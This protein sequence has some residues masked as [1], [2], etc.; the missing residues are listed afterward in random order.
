MDGV[1]RDLRHGSVARRWK[2]T[3]LPGSGRGCYV[4]GCDGES[5]FPGQRPET[6]V[7]TSPC[8]YGTLHHSG[9]PDRSHER[10]AAILGDFARKTKRQTRTH[11]SAELAERTEEVVAS[12]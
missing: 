12:R 4:R 2:G 5:R 8:V 11:C 6:T 9:G 10:F 7:S 3:H 1:Q